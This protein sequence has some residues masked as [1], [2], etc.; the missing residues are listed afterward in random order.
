MEMVETLKPIVGTVS[1]VFAHM[2]Q[3]LRLERFVEA[4]PIIARWYHGRI[5]SPHA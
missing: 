5:G 4:D 1:N 3:G 2:V